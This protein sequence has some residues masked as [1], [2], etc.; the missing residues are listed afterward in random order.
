MELEAI[1][2]AI[3][4]VGF[5]IACC[6][7]MMTSNNKAIQN[8]TDALHGLTAA[9]NTMIHDK[10]AKIEEIKIGGDSH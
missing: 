7:Y 10:H 8:M 5:P 9:I 2:S 1:M 3:G 6:V 4:S